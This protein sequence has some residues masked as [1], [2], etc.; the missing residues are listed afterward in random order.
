[1]RHN[2]IEN[3]YIDSLKKLQYRIII[4]SMSSYPNALKR[5]AWQIKSTTSLNSSLIREVYV[6]HY[7]LPLDL[8]LLA[9]W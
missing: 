1:M 2:A 8:F 3:A 7:D 4:T 9:R 6:A 5:D